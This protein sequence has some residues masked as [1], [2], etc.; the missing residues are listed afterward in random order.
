MGVKI[1]NEELEGIIEEEEV[2]SE[3]NLQFHR[4]ER[5]VF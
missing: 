5:C 1:C 3:R 2:V 4:E